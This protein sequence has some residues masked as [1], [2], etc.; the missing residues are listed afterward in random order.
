MDIMTANMR[1]NLNVST[2]LVNVVE[3]LKKTIIKCKYNMKCKIVAGPNSG[4][5]GSNPFTF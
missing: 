5:R 3:C 4:F 2:E 1:S